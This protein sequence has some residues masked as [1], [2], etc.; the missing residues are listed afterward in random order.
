MSKFKPYKFNPIDD[1]ELNIPKANQREA[2]EAAAEFLKEQMLDYIGEGK[3]PVDGGEWVRKLS[4]GYK[5]VK[6]EES[7]VNFANLELHGDFLDSLN[8]TVKGKSLVLDVGKDQYG[9]AEGHLTG[10]YGSGNMSKGPT[11]R[12]FMPQ[13]KGEFKSK[14]LADLKKLLEDYEE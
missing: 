8:V 5:A 2:L 9:K 13:G 1:L 4:P 12:E 11:P 7:S 10:Q 3:S 14:I 6:G